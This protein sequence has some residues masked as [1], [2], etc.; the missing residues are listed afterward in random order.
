MNR[1]ATP[2]PIPTTTKKKKHTFF[3]Q[4]SLGQLD[5]R[6]RKIKLNNFQG[7]G[8]RNIRKTMASSANIENYLSWCL[9]NTEKS[10]TRLSKHDCVQPQPE[11]R[12]NYD[13]E[14]ARCN[15]HP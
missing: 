14:I 9:F 12:R 5:Q 15:H 4:D 10:N 3:N 6:E 13:R 8:D 1:V 2:P 7:K 11:N